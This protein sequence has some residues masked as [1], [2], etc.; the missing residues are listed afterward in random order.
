ME[1]LRVGGEPHRRERV[2]VFVSVVHLGQQ[3]V[4]VDLDFGILHGR[5]HSLLDRRVAE[6]GDARLGGCEDEMDTMS[7]DAKTE[8]RLHGG[9]NIEAVSID[10]GMVWEDT[11]KKQIFCGYLFF[12]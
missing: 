4:T 2:L 5:R 7:P 6:A 8:Q 10:N 1:G 9:E 3:A 12:V 11:R